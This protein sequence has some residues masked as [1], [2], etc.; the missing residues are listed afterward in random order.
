M[1]DFKKDLSK[2]N[3][4]G[5]LVKNLLCFDKM[6]TPTLIRI[7]FFLGIGFSVFIGFSFIIRGMNA[8]FGGGLLVLMGI[9]ILIISPILIRVYCELM[10]VI[11]KIHESL[12]EIRNKQ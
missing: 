3:E 11:F 7:L 12:L 9:I 6:I 5:G 10:I 2:L 1:E 4:D 8:Y